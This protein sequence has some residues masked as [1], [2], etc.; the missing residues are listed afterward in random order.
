MRHGHGR[1]LTPDGVLYEGDFVDDV[2]EGN[3]TLLW[4]NGQHYQGH[5]SNG[6][7]HGSAPPL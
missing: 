2:K 7:M 1:L 3:G 4:K 5:F 6:Q